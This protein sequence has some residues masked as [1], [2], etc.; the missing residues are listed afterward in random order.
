MSKARIV[1]TVGG[2]ALALLSACAETPVTPV[3]GDVDTVGMPN[4]ELALQRS[5]DRVDAAMRDLGRMG[6]Y[7][8]PAL[9]P[10][11]PPELRHPATLAWSGLIDD[12]VKTLADRVGYRLVV[13]KPA[14][15]QPITVAVNM[16]DVPMLDLF[17]AL[18]TLAGALAT[19]VVDPEHHQ[20]E[21][22]H[23]V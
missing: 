1:S 6:G 20:V 16:A 10:V 21:V 2:A 15:P 12:G 22:Q 7:A 17:E 9:A 13:T 3:A 8:Q 4:A 19:V 5:M 23:H 11:I 18:G 14:N